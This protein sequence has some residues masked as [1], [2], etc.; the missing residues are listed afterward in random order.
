MLKPLIEY[1][2]NYL[3]QH[4]DSILRGDHQDDMTGQGLV[5]LWRT[6]N[7]WVGQYWPDD[8]TQAPASILMG[9]NDTAN[10][11][12]KFGAAQWAKQT[13]K[14]LGISFESSVG[15]WWPQLQQLWA[16]ANYKLIKSLTHDYID[17]VNR[18]TS[19]AVQN[20]WTYKSLMTE[21]LAT[22][23]QITQSRA[24]LIARD[25]IGKL[26]SSISRAQQT[27]VGANTYDWET[28]M[29]ER[30]RPTHRTMQGLTC[31]WDDASIVS[32]DHGRTWVKK[33]GNMEPNQAGMAIQCRCVA[34]AN[35]NNLISDVDREID[36]N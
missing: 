17:K 9:I 25:Q 8:P 15:D 22:G 18:L 10:E 33:S 20:G 7:A 2:Q 26:N 30:V 29:D 21:I 11:T 12:Q 6:L 36:G 4:G 5:Y 19:Q 3:R 28:S 32:H 13:E 27:E 24:R 34:I 35:L 14:L 23:A 31:S 1:T 16:A